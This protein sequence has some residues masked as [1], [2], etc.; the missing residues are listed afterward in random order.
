ME[1]GHAGAWDY[2]WS[3]FELTCEVVIEADDAAKSST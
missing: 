1:R 2:P 3:V